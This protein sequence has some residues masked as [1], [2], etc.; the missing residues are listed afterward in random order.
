MANDNIRL[1]ITADVDDKTGN[2]IKTIKGNLK[3][4]P[5]EV[6]TKIKADGKQAKKEV[7][8]VNKK[9]E[10][11]NGKNKEIKVTAT[12]TQ[13]LNTINSIKKSLSELPKNV[14]TKIDINAKEAKSQLDS[15]KKTLN[16]ISKDIS[17]TVKLN[18]KQADT[19]IESYKKK[20]KDITA[21][22]ETNT[23]VRLDTRSALASLNNLNAKLKEL[24]D[25][26]LKLKFSVEGAA[27]I[28]ALSNG[29][30]SFNKSADAANK[31]LDKLKNISET[32]GKIE[33]NVG[34]NVSINGADETSNKLKEIYGLLKGI[35]E[36][37][38]VKINANAN[39]NGGS[40]RVQAQPQGS[41]RSGS[42]LGS[43]ESQLRGIVAKAEQAHMRGDAQE[44]AKLRQ[45]YVLTTQ[46]MLNFQRQFGNGDYN[47]A[48][49][50]LTPIVQTLQRLGI[51]ARD[52]LG[53]IRELNNMQFNWDAQMKASTPRTYK[54]MAQT[55]KELAEYARQ[56]GNLAE[57]DN[58][59][60][61][62][63]RLEAEAR[64]IN[65]A[66]EVQRTLQ[67]N[68]EQTLKEQI[69]SLEKIAAEQRM[70]GDTRNLAYTEDRLRQLKQEE[71]LAKA[72]QNPDAY[73]GL[74]QEANVYK[75]Q[76]ANPTL[77]PE[78]RRQLYTQIINT[79]SNATRQGLRDGMIDNRQAAS[80]YQKL[81]PYAR[82]LGV[83]N[84]LQNEIT[85]LG[86]A[87]NNAGGQQANNARNEYNDLKRQAVQAIE[88]IN[89]A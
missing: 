82:E 2:S 36:Y 13:A 62:A 16:S 81:M 63:A 69:K 40:P 26:D 60:R 65:T 14:S 8:D 17:T 39:V 31:K 45:E 37:S 43:Y 42:N 33:K 52:D 1:H 68:I 7:D 12:G 88:D 21:P 47:N 57:S 79:V 55:E 74:M 27:A 75:E 34:I 48:I 50:K 66:L 32:L 15:L 77:T 70:Q 53:P 61:N 3:E 84:N 83:E 72:R 11:L 6:T 73:K 41:N 18:H 10:Q 19:S 25:S 30:Q 89:R 80:N 44:L 35:R 51:I 76:L 24:K 5:A 38:N 67:G 54:Q 86:G 29:I 4:I 46:E 58:H 71:Q 56:N 64:S 23:K 20:L 9:L 49:K 87:T 85:R 78:A 28:K 22:I 59:L